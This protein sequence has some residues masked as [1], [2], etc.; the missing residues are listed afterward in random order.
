MPANPTVASAVVMSHFISTRLPN[1]TFFKIKTFKIVPTNP[2][3]SKEGA[4]F[5]TRKGA[6]F[7]KN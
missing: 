5:H 3:I 7:Q 4:I 2:I 1:A 6:S